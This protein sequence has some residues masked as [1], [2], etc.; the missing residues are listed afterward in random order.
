M[1]K[2]WTLSEHCTYIIIVYIFIFSSKNLGSKLQK[3]WGTLGSDG[4]VSWAKVQNSWWRGRDSSLVCFNF[5]ARSTFVEFLRLIKSPDTWS[6]DLACWWL[7]RRS[8]DQTWAVLSPSWNIGGHLEQDSQSL[9]RCG[10][11]AGD[12]DGWLALELDVL[13]TRRSFDV[14]VGEFF[15][16]DVDVGEFDG[17]DSSESSPLVSF[18]QHCSFNSWLSCDISTLRFS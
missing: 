18:S 13:D 5:K 7:Y 10:H 16:V 9:S 12:W 4:S 15:D 8:F 11:L 6:N 3:T 2:K 14:D 1:L 17:R